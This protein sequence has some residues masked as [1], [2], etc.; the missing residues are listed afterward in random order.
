MKRWWLVVALCL[1][2]GVNIGVLGMI[3]LHRAARPGPMGPEPSVQRGA[4][5]VEALADRL[6]LQGEER[7]E[8][9]DLQ[10]EFFQKIRVQRHEIGRLRQDLRRE[11]SARRP[12]RDVV[13]RTL[14]AM[15]RSQA[16]LDRAFA[17]SILATRELLGPRQ[18]WLYF[19]FLER[20]RR[21]AEMAGR[22][23]DSVPRR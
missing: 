19:R 18:E 10:R 11:L 23:T 5:P 21:Q 7:E 17:D 3:L 16:E 9:L 13:N 6:G 22:P 4:P 14:D 15:A 1:S 20:V 2:L 8:F 12:D